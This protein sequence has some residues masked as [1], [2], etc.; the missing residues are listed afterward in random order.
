MQKLNEQQELAVKT[1]EGYIRVIAGAGS[2][3]NTNNYK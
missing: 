2:R 1:T 3:K